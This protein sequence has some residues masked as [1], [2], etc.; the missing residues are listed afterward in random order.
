[1]DRAHY[2]K[3]ADGTSRVV[4]RLSYLQKTLYFPPH[5][6]STCAGKAIWRRQM[7][8]RVK[9]M[10]NNDDKERGSTPV[11]GYHLTKKNPVLSG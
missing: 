6:S 11:R 9:I 5:F 3:K 8:D 10:P 1:M 4:V 7:L 2:V